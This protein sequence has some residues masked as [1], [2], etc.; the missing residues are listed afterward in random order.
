MERVSWVD[1]PNKAVRGGGALTHV[2]DTRRSRLEMSCCLLVGRHT[3][4]RMLKTT[5][6]KG[7]VCV[8]WGGGGGGVANSRV[9][10]LVRI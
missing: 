10:R 5:Y 6:G 3:H 9:K 7:G 8:G 2:V 1:M 4:T